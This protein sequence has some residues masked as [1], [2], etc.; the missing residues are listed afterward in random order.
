MVRQHEVVGRYGGEEFIL[1]IAANDEAAARSLNQRVHA[2][3]ASVTGPG[4]PVT[5]SVG[6]CHRLQSGAHSL[7]DIVKAA[8]QALY[9]AKASGRNCSMI[10]RNGTLTSFG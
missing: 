2:A 8:D 1:A 10:E 5:V 9:A 3:A 7:D 6:L 4:A